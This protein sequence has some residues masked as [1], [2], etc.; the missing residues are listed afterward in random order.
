[1]L[2]IGKQDGST[3][4]I[5]HLAQEAV[6]AGLPEN[7]EV[8]LTTDWASRCSTLMQDA[9]GPAYGMTLHCLS[10][11]T[12]IRP[13]EDTTVLGYT[14]AF[15]LGALGKYASRYEL[16]AFGLL[17]WLQAQEGEI[18]QAVPA[19]SRVP[20]TQ[21]LVKREPLAPA[22]IP[23]AG[24]VAQAP[25]RAPEGL[26]SRKGGA[27]PAP[28]GRANQSKPHHMMRWQL[29][30]LLVVALGLGYVI[31]HDPEPPITKA[32]AES[33]A[34]TVALIQRTETDAAP[35]SNVTSV[36]PKAAAEPLPPG[37]YD[38]TADTYIYDTGQ[39]TTLRLAD[40]T[41]LKI[42]ATSTESQLYKFL[43]DPSMQ[44][45]SV[46]RTKGWINCDRIYF[47]KGQAI[48][49]E[50]SGEQLRNIA[51]ILRAFPAARVKFG[52][53]T[54]STGNALTN[55]QLSESRAKAAMLALSSI[56]IDMKRLESKGYGGKFFLTTNATPE[57]RA[58]NR[59]V[60]LRVIKK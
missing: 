59:R 60:S 38:P 58:M 10:A 50:G 39:P 36:E 12:G 7:A 16:P 31:G 18:L 1:M 47:E 6:A 28:F 44:V 14:L 43:S 20:S 45:D 15:T 3:D 54:D 8:L 53:Y 55:F 30:G 21:Q 4:V 19:Y 9:L 34:S 17:H 40:G 5:G 32:K 24:G 26:M 51:S 56:G 29:A 48:L 33:P 23:G 27:A 57:G 2:E 37:H 35:R 42:G 25:V 22:T 13:V 52:G 41:T 46:N 11:A 49:T